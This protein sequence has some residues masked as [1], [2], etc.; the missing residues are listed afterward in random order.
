[1]W[2]A[3]SAFSYPASEAKT[4]HPVIERFFGS[5]EAVRVH[6]VLRRVR[7]CRSAG[8]AIAGGRAVEIHA[9]RSGLNPPKRQLGDVD[10][11]AL[12]FDSAPPTLSDLFLFRHI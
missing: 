12:N 6:D 10:F 2:M 5:S 8:L 1:M 4:T 3:G 7:E 9:V 11:V